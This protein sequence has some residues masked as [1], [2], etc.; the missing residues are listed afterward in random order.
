MRGF[1]T[2]ESKLAEVGYI[3][4]GKSK[5]C[6]CTG[7]GGW[8]VP[9]V[10]TGSVKTLT[11]QPLNVKLGGSTAVPEFAKC[12]GGKVGQWMVGA[13]IF[14]WPSFGTTLLVTN[15][16]K[17]FTGFPMLFQARLLIY[18]KTVNVL[19]ASSDLNGLLW[20]TVV[21][22]SSSSCCSKAVIGFSTYTSFSK[23]VLHHS[24]K[25]LPSNWYH[26]IPWFLRVF[27]SFR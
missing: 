26:G 2:K 23:S 3:C 6:R 4:L 20:Y 27:R 13:R 22:D 12:A 9:L 21:V 1:N 10:M 17:G 14:W 5:R 15:V 18:S 25:L 19:V 7:G 24:I 8:N 16:S 11:E